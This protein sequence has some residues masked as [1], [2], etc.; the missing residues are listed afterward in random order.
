MGWCG[1]TI[2]FITWIL[3]IWLPHPNTDF[4]PA[5]QVICVD[6]YSYDTRDTPARQTHESRETHLRGSRAA[7]IHLPTPST[8]VAP[9]PHSIASTRPTMHPTHVF[10]FLCSNVHTP[11]DTLLFTI[12]QPVNGNRAHDFQYTHPRKNSTVWARASKTWNIHWNHAKDPV[13]SI[14]YTDYVSVALL[15]QLAWISSKGEILLLLAAV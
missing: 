10:Y 11:H 14:T 7:P 12:S 13:S 5:T 9:M 2:P 3:L 6:N 15:S 1:P 4:T 8:Y